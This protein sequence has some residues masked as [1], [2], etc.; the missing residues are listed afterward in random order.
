MHLTSLN[1]SFK[2]IQI[3]NRMLSCHNFLKIFY[4]TCILPVC[5]LC[6]THLCLMPSEVRKGRWILRVRRQSVLRSAWAQEAPERQENQVPQAVLLTS[7]CTYAHALT[8]I[9][10]FSSRRS[11]LM[12]SS[13]LHMWHPLIQTHTQK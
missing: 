8:T 12:V 5:T 13:N 2:R 10:T 6:A 7:T 1:S 11:D 4:L 3:V 9:Y